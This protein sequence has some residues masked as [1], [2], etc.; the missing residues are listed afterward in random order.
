MINLK[1]YEE[2]SIDYTFEDYCYSIEN[3]FID[4]CDKYSSKYTFVRNRADKNASHYFD[5]LNSVICSAKFDESKVCIGVI[6]D[7]YYYDINSDD[8]NIFN[9]D[10]IDDIKNFIKR[11]ENYYTSIKSKNEIDLFN[12]I[13]KIMNSRKIDKKEFD[14]ILSDD[15]I[16]N[17][18]YLSNNI[19]EKIKSKIAMYPISNQN[20][21]RQRFL[22]LSICF[23][24]EI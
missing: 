13:D 15:M 1:L 18:N 16:K 3:L 23:T 7:R 20:D 12:I 5:R 19:P 24:W 21:R 2:F 17:I 9:K 8:L 22:Y 11:I 14:E 10:F 4:M 6:P